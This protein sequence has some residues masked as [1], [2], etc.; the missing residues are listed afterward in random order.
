MPKRSMTRIV[1]SPNGSVA[2]DVGG[3]ADGRGAYVCGREACVGDGLRRQRLSFALRVSVN[4]DDWAQIKRSIS[5]SGRDE[6]NNE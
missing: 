3:K 4:D 5:Q 1:A 6:V 2:A